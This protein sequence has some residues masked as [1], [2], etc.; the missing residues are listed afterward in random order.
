M[1]SFRQTDDGTPVEV[2]DSGEG[3]AAKD[4]GRKGVV[5]TLKQTTFRSL[6]HRNYRLYFLGQL[7]S[8]TGSW[9][10]NAALMWLMYD[11]TGD[12]RWPSYLLVAQVGPTVLLGTWGGH[13]ADRLPKR[14][15][16]FRTQSAFLVNAVFLTILVA[17]GWLLPALV[18]ALQVASGL[19]QAIDLPA[20]LAFVPDLVP[21]DDLINAVGLNSLLFN[22]AR[23]IGPAVTGMLFL[24][25]A[26]A[27]RLLHP[28]I[29]PVEFGAICCFGINSLSFV[30]VLFALR[31]IRVAGDVHA[32]DHPKAGSAWDGVRYLFQRRTLGGL[33][34][35]TLVLCVF[36]WPVI[37]LFPGY[38][39]ERLGLA[40]ESY[41]FLVSAL[42]GGALVAALATA[43]FGSATRRGTFLVAGATVTA[44]GVFGLSAVASLPP[45]VACAG[46]VGFGL[47]L[48]LSTGQSTLQLAVPNETRGRVMALWAIT[49]SA[50]APIGH[51]LAGMAAAELGVVPV[52]R[53]MA[54]GVGTVAVGLAVLL[55]RR[56]R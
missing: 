34:L 24:V 9:M 45:A 17:S 1:P 14:W 27:A 3:Q 31:G 43:T 49:L 26:D 42:G 30:A 48:F 5:A 13:L 32:D 52:L 4:E 20:R 39:R 11:R 53:V 16:I 50:S 8:F 51:L 23:A 35:L 19:V 28:G 29:K 12:L 46:C 2:T 44:G 7:V 56:R 10:Q 37:T 55:M 47:I 36:A 33:V 6:R 15:L 54:I 25:A 18:L 41:S 40:E 21:K 22:S 38:T